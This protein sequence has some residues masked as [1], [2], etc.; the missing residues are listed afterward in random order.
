MPNAVSS[1]GAFL[2]TAPGSSAIAVIRISGPL[3]PAFLQTHFNK[4]AKL[5]RAVHG[6]LKD[7]A[8]TIDDPVV[9]LCA[10]D[11]A[12]I[13]VHGGP[14]MVRSTMELCR[15]FGFEVNS[16][17]NQPLPVEAVDGE[18]EIWREVLHYLPMAK[19]ELATRMLL[20][21]PAAWERE[22][23]ASE[24]KE[25]LADRTLTTMLSLPRVAIVG[26]A[27]VGKSTLANQLF[28]MERS[29]TA[30]V[31]G[32]T[33]D[34]VGEIA[35]VDG[36]AVML[37]DTPGQRETSDEIEAAAISLS[38]DQI[39][40]ADLVVV[41]L[42]GSI[43]IV[44]EEQAIIDR[45]PDA[46]RVANKADRSPAWEFDSLNAIAISALSGRGVSELRREILQRL[47]CGDLSI[48]KPRCW[49]ELQRKRLQV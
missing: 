21:Q 42:D 7:G 33:R 38:Q 48:D 46:I 18:T 36:L 19:M 12:D 35:N 49:T 27:N 31:P 14:W 28:A 16:R 6:E 3:V 9:V 23:S 37:L 8:K 13:N 10:G 44:A 5:N 24:K 15:G 47:G 43:G 20:A 45:Y 1:N 4:S 22:F 25:I 11:V 30:D 17:L 29:I 41:V 40:G 34:W 26:P 32:T 39:A 2:L